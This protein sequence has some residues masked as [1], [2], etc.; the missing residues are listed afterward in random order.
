M[1]Q[2]LSGGKVAEASGVFAGHTNEHT[3]TNSSMSPPIHPAVAAAAV[4]V[5]VSGTTIFSD[6]EVL[7]ALVEITSSI[8]S[9]LDASA[10]QLLITFCRAEASHVACDSQIRM[11]VEG[12]GATQAHWHATPLHRPMFE[13]HVQLSARSRCDDVI[14]DI[15]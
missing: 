15:I 8:A 6:E 1:L 4:S 11:S 9:A 12:S 3:T 7:K 13:K 14:V 10:G 2:H 5:V